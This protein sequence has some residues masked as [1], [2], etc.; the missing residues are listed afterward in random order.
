MNAMY[1]VIVIHL[2]DMIEPV[3]PDDPQLAATNPSANF[4]DLYLV[5]EFMETDMYKT[6]YS[7][8]RLTDDHIQYFVYQVH[9]YLPTCAHAS[10]LPIVSLSHYT[11]WC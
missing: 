1:G 8:N 9:L 2:V 4:N 10:P 6:I 11:L 5:M 3:P 7:S